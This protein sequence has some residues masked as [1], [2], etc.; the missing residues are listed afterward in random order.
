MSDPGSDM[1]ATRRTGEGSG[2]HDGLPGSG[3]GPLRGPG[4][5]GFESTFET[6]RAAG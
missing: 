4:G 1:S 3:G 5:G 2:V 6:S